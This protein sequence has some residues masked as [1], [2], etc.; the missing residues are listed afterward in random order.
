MS[1]TRTLEATAVKEGKWWNI[2]IPEL[3]QVTATKKINEVQEYAE[4]LAAAILD[5]PTEQL[6]VNVKFD[7]PGAVAA[8]W[9]AARADTTQAKDL[10]IAAAART[11]AVIEK[12]HT[13]G[14]SMRD[15]EKVLGMSFQRVSQILKS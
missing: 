7:M 5:V 4:S 10:T 2:T 3:D 11:R 6:Q 12:L 9:D 8:E 1:V 15:I 13:D 14:Y